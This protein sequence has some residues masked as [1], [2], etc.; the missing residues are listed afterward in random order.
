MGVEYCLNMGEPELE[1]YQKWLKEN[2]Y[3]SPL[4]PEFCPSVFRS[5]LDTW[6][7][8]DKKNFGKKSD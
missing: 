8:R 7:K 4:D 6:K 2:N 1:S 3:K 5:D